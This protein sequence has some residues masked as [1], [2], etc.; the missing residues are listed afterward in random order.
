MGNTYV[1]LLEIYSGVSVLL[2][3]VGH[4]CV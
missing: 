3:L 2:C 1:R 4:G